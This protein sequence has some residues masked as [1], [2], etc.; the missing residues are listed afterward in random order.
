MGRKRFLAPLTIASALLIG[1]STAQAQTGLSLWAGIGGSR[2]AGVS[3][4]AKD[5]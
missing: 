5:A 3:T 2:E 1:A 4:F